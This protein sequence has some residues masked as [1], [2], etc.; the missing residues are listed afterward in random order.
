[1]DDTFMLLYMLYKLGCAGLVVALLMLIA[2]V[3][4]IIVHVGTTVGSATFQIRI[5]AT[6][7]LALL[8]LTI[9]M[10]TPYYNELKAWVYYTTTESTSDK[11]K[12]EKLIQTTFDYIDGKVK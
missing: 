12:A 9:G 1:M 11:E 4:Q 7:I 5:T 10:I 3:V 6:I 8:G 2:T